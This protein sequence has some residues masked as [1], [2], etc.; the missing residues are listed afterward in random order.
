MSDGS[1]LLA[2]LTEE[3]EIQ[4]RARLKRKQTESMMEHI[5]EVLMGEVIV[6][7]DD[8]L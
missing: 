6:G 4:R 1:E 3:Y 2:K 7:N 5:Y 8:D